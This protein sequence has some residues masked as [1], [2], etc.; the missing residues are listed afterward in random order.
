[1]KEKFRVNSKFLSYVYLFALITTN[2]LLA[3][4]CPNGS[5]APLCPDSG[6]TLLD[7]TYPTQAF[8]I[9]NAPMKPGIQSSKVTSEYI[10]AIAKSYDYENMP[11]VFVPIPNQEGMKKIIDDL[12]S[13]GKS[14]LQ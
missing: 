8:V 6:S 5:S 1:M 12:K 4:E 10:S 13:T 7:E 9:S 2:Q 14:L 11:Q 3:V